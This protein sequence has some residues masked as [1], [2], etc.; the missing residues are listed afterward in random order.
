M[1][2]ISVLAFTLT[3]AATSVQAGQYAPLCGVAPCG[4][5]PVTASV[6]GEAPS[7]GPAARSPRA[8]APELV[9]A[10]VPALT[11]EDVRVPRAGAGLVQAGG[12]PGPKLRPR[13]GSVPPVTQAAASLVVPD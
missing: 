5:G 6:A 2:R 13:S 1:I 9:A 10:S 8:N 3:A 12:A 4:A 11:V 7:R